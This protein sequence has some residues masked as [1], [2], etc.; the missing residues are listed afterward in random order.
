MATK[1]KPGGSRSR[2]TAKKAKPRKNGATQQSRS[3]SRSRSASVGSRSSGG[4]KRASK[5]RA[6]NPSKGRKRS[7]GRYGR[8]QNPLSV[9]GF[10]AILK[11]LGYAGGGA[12]AVSTLS[13][14]VP[15]PVTSPLGILICQGIL[16]WIVGWIGGKVFGKANESMIRV[17]GFAYAAGNFVTNQFPNLQQRILSLSP[18]NFA[19]SAMVPAGAAQQAA[20]DVTGAPPMTDS[21]MSSDELSD[22]SLAH[23]Y[24]SDI[25]A[26]QA[27]N[28]GYN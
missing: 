3:R 28:F 25:S 18:L 14:M 2:K 11:E 10:G 1:K 26:V 13:Q 22:I 19:R 4:Y 15:I 24:L 8:S 9:R 20:I 5:P 6:Q 21:I 16:A 7:R 17:G 12:F 27:G 23:P